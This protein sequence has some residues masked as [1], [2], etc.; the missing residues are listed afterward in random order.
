MWAAIVQNH[1]CQSIYT[2]KTEDR[3]L[4]LT[5]PHAGHSLDK[6]KWLRVRNCEDVF[7][8]HTKINAV[9]PRG[10]S[11]EIL[12][13]CLSRVLRG[14]PITTTHSIL[15]ATLCVSLVLLQPSLVSLRL[16]IDLSPRGESYHC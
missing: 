8:P 2:R 16:R 12:D 14:L 4:L 1:R 13:N 15:Q 9:C 7:P 10:G 11:S 3:G 6:R 5:C